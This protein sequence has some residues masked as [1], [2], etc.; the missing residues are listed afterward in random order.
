MPRVVITAGKLRLLAELNDSD[1]AAQIAA[2]LPFEASANRWGD[3]VYFDI[4]VSAPS[5]ADAQQDVQLGDVAYWPPG[6]A[7]CLFFGPTPVSQGQR[8]RAA[9]PV[10]LVGRIVGDPTTLRQ[11]RDGDRV[12]VSAE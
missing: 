11:V 5:E 8:P 12:T 10:N 7:L 9:S 3:E 1:T 4:P 6:S 2:A